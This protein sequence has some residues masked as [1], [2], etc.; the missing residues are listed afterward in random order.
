MSSAVGL[1]SSVNDLLAWSQALLRA[2]VDQ[3]E[4]G[5]ASTPDLP[6][7]HLKNIMSGHYPLISF[8]PAVLETLLETSNPADYE[9]LSRQTAAAA[10]INKFTTLNEKLK[11][12]WI[13]GTH[14]KLLHTYIGK[15]YNS[16]KNFFLSHGR[17]SIITTTLFLGSCPV[18]NTSSVLIFLLLPRIF[19]QVRASGG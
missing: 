15:Y 13:L 14:P 2:L 17:S 11:S 6:L 19:T 16:I 3:R 18:T 1:R 4:P 5:R 12:K 10:S 9:S 8:Y 7:K